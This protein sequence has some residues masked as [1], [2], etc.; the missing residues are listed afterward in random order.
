MSRPS[1]AFLR[2]VPAHDV[3]AALRHERQLLATPLRLI[4]DAEKADVQLGAD[5]LHLAEMSADLAA[6]LVDVLQRRARQLDLTARLQRHR[7]V[8]AIG[9]RDQLAILEDWF[10]AEAGQAPQHRAD[11]LRPVVGQR[12]IVLQPVGEFLVLGADPP[13]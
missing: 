3:V 10:P 2:H 7:A 5:R 9:Q 8:A 12:A 11:A 13:L 4:A 6:G 1:D